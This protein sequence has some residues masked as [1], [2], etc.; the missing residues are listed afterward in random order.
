MEGFSRCVVSVSK[1]QQKTIT[2]GELEDLGL[3][4]P[5]FRPPPNGP[6]QFAQL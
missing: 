5:I 2:D 1:L 6:V 3:F 4:A